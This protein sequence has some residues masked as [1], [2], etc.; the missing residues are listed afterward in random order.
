M[1][2]HNTRGVFAQWPLTS[3]KLTGIRIDESGK[4]VSRLCFLSHDPEIYVNE[5]AREIEPLPEVEKPKARVSK[6][7]EGNGGASKAEVR[8]MLA[9][10]PKRPHYHDW[11]TV[12][13]AVGDALSDDDAIEALNEWSPEEAPGEYARE[14]QTALRKFMSGRLFTW[15]YSTGTRRKPMMTAQTL[16]RFLRGRELNIRRH[17]M[18]AAY[19]GLAGDIVRRIEPHTEADRR[20][21]GSDPDSIRQRHRPQCTRAWRTVRGTP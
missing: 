8:E 6:S 16:L 3:F 20:F 9:V 1:M 10:I 17:L 13:A 4:D 5:K 11:I 21:V 14:L 19:Y 12:V 15:P 18:K 2:H 7:T